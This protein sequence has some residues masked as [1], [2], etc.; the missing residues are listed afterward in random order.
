MYISYIFVGPMCNTWVILMHTQ[1]FSETWREETTLKNLDI[2]GGILLNLFFRW[3]GW[4]GF[5]WT[6]CWTFE[7]HERMWISR[8][9][10]R[11]LVAAC[12]PWEVL[13]PAVYQIW[14]PGQFMCNLLGKTIALGQI[15]SLSR[16]HFTSAPCS[17]II[18]F[19]FRGWNCNAA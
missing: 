3:E 7:F 17:S 18:L 16:Y 5:P 14:R 19:R 1:Y 9:A 2:V 11:L 4:A 15:V 8:L 12:W 6:W 10:E 13:S